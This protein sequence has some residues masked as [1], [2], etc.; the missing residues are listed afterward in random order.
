LAYSGRTTLKL[1]A[2]NTGEFTGG[3][4]IVTIAGTLHV[5]IFWG[6]ELATTSDCRRHKPRVTLALSMQPEKVRSQFVLMLYIT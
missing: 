4:I 6:I 3:S 2:A 1:I 5:T